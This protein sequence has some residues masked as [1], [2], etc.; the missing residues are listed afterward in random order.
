MDRKRDRKLWSQ[1]LFAGYDVTRTCPYLTRT[2]LA[3]AEKAS[4]S[5]VRVC[6][7]LQDIKSQEEFQQN[8][9]ISNEVKKGIDKLI[10]R[11]NVASQVL[12]ELKKEVDAIVLQAENMRSL[13]LLSDKC[14]PKLYILRAHGLD[15]ILRNSIAEEVPVVDPMI[16][17]CLI[18]KLFL[19]SL[20]EHGP[21]SQLTTG[22]TTAE[23]TLSLVEQN[24][25]RYAAGFVVRKLLKKHH[26]NESP[27]ANAC[28]SCLKEMTAE[29]NPDC[30][31]TGSFN[32]YRRIWISMTDR[33][34]LTHVNNLTFSIFIE[35]EKLVQSKLL[36]SF[37]GELSVSKM[38]E[39]IAEDNDIKFLWSLQ[40]TCITS[41]KLEKELLN[42]LIK[43]WVVLRG[44]SLTN[45]YLEMY[46]SNI[47]KSLSKK[48]GLRKQLQVTKK[49]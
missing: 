8:T 18:D 23:I 30:S 31:Q 11:K 7:L 45:K 25:V 20:L 48:K 17:Q 2:L 3:M 4:A 42:E 14:R 37:H 43:E 15:E 28:G 36:S 39:E 34:G 19:Q 6:A 38:T 41:D 32:D 21:T 16:W 1:A 47:K 35:F 9:K 24:A 5:E 12:D 44:H 46:K 13:K 40:A 29:D 26:R 10:E 22:A 49:K 27:A 33:G